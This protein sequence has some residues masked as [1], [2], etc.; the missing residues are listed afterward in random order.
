MIEEGEKDEFD[1]TVQVFCS[2]FLKQKAELDQKKCEKRQ[3]TERQKSSQ[4]TLGEFLKKSNATCLALKLPNDGRLY[5]CRMR[6]SSHR[7]VNRVTLAAGLE[8]FA[9]QLQ[10][11]EQE[12]TR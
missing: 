5:L 10:E 7:Q 6:Q 11:S 1:R 8:S 3:W 9:R 2:Q 12:T 4:Q